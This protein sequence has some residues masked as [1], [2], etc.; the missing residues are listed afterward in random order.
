MA[1]RRV[2]QSTACMF[3]LLAL[4]GSSIL[5]AADSDWLTY[6]RT[7]A[8]DRYSPLKEIN[9][10]NVARLKLICTYTLPEVSSLQ[11]GPI[12]V[13]GTMFFTTDE[14]S[15]AIDASTCAEK[16]KVHRHSPTPSMLLV[17]RGFAYDN[18]R[19]FRG[20]SDSHVLA[21]GPADGHVIWDQVLD[22][23]G[24]GVSIP[25]APIAA[26]GLVYVG[27]AGGDQVGVTGHVYALDERDGHVA[28]KFDVVPATGSA[29]STWTNPEL[30]ISGGAFWTS[31]TLDEPAGVLYVPA[32]NP[33]PDFAS[34]VRTGDNLYSNSV[35]ALDAAT[36]QML[37]YNQLVKH[38]SHDWD[39]DAAPTLATTRSGKRIIASANKDGLLSIL[40]RSRVTKSATPADP[41]T[42]LPLLSQ[43]ATTT[44]ENVN[45]PLSRDHKVHFCP[46]IQGGVEWNG[47][48]FSPKS[49]SLFVAAVDWCA[50]VQVKRDVEQVGAP[51]T[52]FL[53]AENSMSDIFD[54]PEKATGWITAFDAETGRVRWKYHAPHP[55]LAGVTPTAGGLVFAADL[56]G[57]IYAFDA[58]RGRILWQT[59]AGQ[60]TGGG[61]VSYRAG[62]RQLLGVASGMKSPIWPGAA[63][64]SA[65]R[66][67]GLP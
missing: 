26:N 64:Q 12:V 59:S 66:V 65:I 1:H 63:R 53:G 28:W 39:V 25:M 51:G 48:A 40:D 67:Y 49:N 17:N 15:Y 55:M 27:N 54:A 62:G 61:I 32:G 52:L 21:M 5:H 30:P 24:P 47:A 20:T 34:E 38:D 56:G 42:V 7:L 58:D 11:T 19:L 35:I 41:A 36:G 57:Q 60:S 31:F 13:D 44:R 3:G 50:N 6:N 37:G 45:T 46:G 8:G 10:S 33:A 43:T 9:R 4:V 14:G 16:W 2:A 22:I 23:Q 18:G 29:R